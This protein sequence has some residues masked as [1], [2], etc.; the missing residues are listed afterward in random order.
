MNFLAL[1]QPPLLRKDQRTEKSGFLCL[2][3]YKKATKR[4]SYPDNIYIY[5][6]YIKHIHKYKQRTIAFLIEEQHNNIS[7]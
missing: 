3:M 2:H 4:A 1:K 7:A 5:V 6:A